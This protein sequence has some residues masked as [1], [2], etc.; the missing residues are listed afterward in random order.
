MTTDQGIPVEAELTLFRPM[1]GKRRRG[2]RRFRC[3]LAT[4][5][6]LH[7]PDSGDTSDAC[8]YNLSETG[9]GLNMNSSL[10]VDTEMIIH[11]RLP[12]SRESLKLSARVVHATQ[13]V[14]RSWRVGC[15]FAEPLTEEVVEA[16][17]E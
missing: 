17:L 6:K 3:G 1:L 4:I 16:M 5:G 11:L 7:F 9:I 12:T 14:D 2:A 8:V 13:E 10:A 15:V